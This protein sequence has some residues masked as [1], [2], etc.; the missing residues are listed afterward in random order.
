MATT[1][2]QKAIPIE[3]LNP[4]QLLMVKKNVEEVIYFRLILLIEFLAIGTFNV[5]T[6]V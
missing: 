6:I 1:E 2:P 5:I 3:A 4:Q